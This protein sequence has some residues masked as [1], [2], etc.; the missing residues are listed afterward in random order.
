MRTF[1]RITGIGAAAVATLA[2]VVGCSSPAPSTSG[3]SQEDFGLISAGTLTVGTSGSYPPYTFVTDAGELTGYDVDVITE[4]ADRL[5]L[6]PDIQAVDFNALLAG[7][8]AGRYDAVAS[9]ISI[10]D[11][12]SPDYLLTDATLVD[13]VTLLVMADSD[14]ESL[15]DLDGKVL[16]GP[17]G[18]AAFDTM[19]RDVEGDWEVVTFPGF[20][21]AVQG[22]K[23]G[24]V[25]A[26]AVTHLL[27]NYIT[28][29][30][31]SLRVLDDIVGEFHSGIAVSSKGGD[32]LK[33][34]MDAA[35]ADMLEDGTIEDLQ[36]KYFG[37][38]ALP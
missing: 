19:E 25:D 38:V 14:I 34:A 30:D 28:T 6:T 35:I 7:L 17:T 11:D 12:E 31:D 18:T 8:T 3:E 2:L 27:G 10:E 21:E 1:R 23:D 22:L 9:A 5:G 24:R 33:A 37:T 4:I 32:A 13:G 20:A 36:Q 29:D 26:L 15:A 16:G